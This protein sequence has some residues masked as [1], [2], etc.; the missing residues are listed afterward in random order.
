MHIHVLMY[1]NLIFSV[2]SIS[3]LSAVRIN[4]LLFNVT[5]H[6]NYYG[7]R[8]IN[9]V[10]LG[11]KSTEG[12]NNHYLFINNL[13]WKREGLTHTALVPINDTTILRERIILFVRVT[14]SNGKSA[15]SNTIQEY[16]SNNNNNNE[17]YGRY[18]LIIVEL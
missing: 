6:F 5:L 13:D 10:K 18:L 16:I 11:Y 7:G 17:Y 8:D 3:S 15:D 12:A 1:L 9:N 4:P 2:P 14:N